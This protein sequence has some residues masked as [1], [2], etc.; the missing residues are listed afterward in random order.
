MRQQSAAWQ[1]KN[2][3][4]LYSTCDQRKKVV[5][6][7]KEEGK[8]R[9]NDRKILII[10]NPT[11][12]RRKENNYTHR[13]EW[14]PEELIHVKSFMQLSSEL[15]P[16]NQRSRLANTFGCHRIDHKL[17]PSKRSRGAPAELPGMCVLPTRRTEGTISQENP[18]EPRENHD[19]LTNPLEEGICSGLSNVIPGLRWGSLLSGQVFNVI[20]PTQPP[21]GSSPDCRNCRIEPQKPDNKLGAKRGSQAERH[22]TEPAGISWGQT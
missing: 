19:Y 14:V 8:K 21:P 2:Q 6:W 22:L 4:T 13:Q 1:Y 9:K 18:T 10:W 15:R 12:A 3:I 11:V 17:L 16:R 7:R 20:V 5:W